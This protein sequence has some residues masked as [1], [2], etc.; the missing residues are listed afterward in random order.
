[1]IVAACSTSAC[2]DEYHSS[3]T[4]RLE[5]GM[6]KLCALIVWAMRIISSGL[7]CI[8]CNVNLFYRNNARRA[9]KKEAS[10]SLRQPTGSQQ[11]QS[12]ACMISFPE[13]SSEKSSENSW[14]K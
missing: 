1:M 7:A 4:R 5:I 14:C 8:S 2:V 12:Q 10:L 3:S 11:K 6:V 13:R 9:P